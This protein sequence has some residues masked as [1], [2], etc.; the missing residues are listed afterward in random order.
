MIAI[1]IVAFSFLAI[2]FS[3]YW[4]YHIHPNVI[5][6]MH[7]TDVIRKYYP[8]TCLIKTSLSI[9]INNSIKFGDKMPI[10]KEKEPLIMHQRPSSIVA[11]LY[12]LRDLDTDIV[13]LHGH[14]GCS[15]KHARLLEENGM[16]FCTSSFDESGFVFGGGSKPHRGIQIRGNAPGDG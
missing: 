13:I 12:T 9:T 10:K 15:F 5:K 7:L 8:I 11:A 3:L 4:N 1:Q 14:P 16:R 2:I 6:N